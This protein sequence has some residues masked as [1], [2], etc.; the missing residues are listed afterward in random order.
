MNR[1]RSKTQRRPLALERDFIIFMPLRWVVV[2]PTLRAVRSAGTESVTSA[3]PGVSS[4]STDIANCS[5]RA[6][7]GCA[8]TPLFVRQIWASPRAPA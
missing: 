7:I 2:H 4:S 3:D 1:V 5:R 8:L 6:S